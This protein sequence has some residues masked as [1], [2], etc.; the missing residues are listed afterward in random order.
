[1]L[2]LL[3]LIVVQLV[4]LAPLGA[5]G[6]NIDGSETTGLEMLK[7][8]SPSVTFMVFVAVYFGQMI[9]TLNAPRFLKITVYA[10]WVGALSVLGIWLQR[11][12]ESGQTAFAMTS[13]FFKASVLDFGELRLIL[14]VA[15]LFAVNLIYCLRRFRLD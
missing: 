9:L 10:A 7:H 15:C 13:E 3:N 6:L 12:Y 8:Y 4:L 5:R 2:L 14:L 11:G 1:M